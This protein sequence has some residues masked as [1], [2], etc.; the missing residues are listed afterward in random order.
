MTDTWKEH[1]YAATVD[2][3]AAYVGKDDRQVLGHLRDA[4]DNIYR[5]IEAVEE[6]NQ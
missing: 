3:A 5:A 1:A 4:A 2:I 6:E